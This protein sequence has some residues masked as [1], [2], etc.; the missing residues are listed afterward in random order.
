V[1]TERSVLRSRP[2]VALLGAEAISSLGSQMTFLA[3]PWFVLVTTGSA[4]KMSIVLAVEILPIALLGIP[5]GALIARFGARTTMVIGD[6]GR[7]PLMLA[8]PLLQK[9]G[10]LTFPLL[11]VFVFLMGC[12][13]A[14][15]FSAQRLILPELVGDDERTVGQANAIFEGTQRATALLGPSMAGVLIAVIGATNVLYLD[16]A[17]YFVSFLILITLVPRRPPIAES[18]DAHG[19]LAGI[20]F[21]FRDYLLRVLAI[22]ALFL[23]MFGQMMVASLPVLAFDEYDES[24]A[25]AGLFFAAFGAGS[26]VG[27]VLAVKLLPKFDP[28]RLGAVALVLLTVP[29][30]LLGLPLPAWAV[31]AVL[32]TGAI[33]GPLVNAPLIGVLTTRTPESLRPKVMTGVITMAM[34]AGPVGLLVVGPLLASWGPRPVLLFVALGQFL[35]SLPF[36]FVALRRREPTVPITLEAA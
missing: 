13:I 21:L 15:Y 28:I 1:T 32:F 20:R 16:A 6:A 17:S 24:S 23:N 7:A 12:F 4:A 34:L 5:S 11:L 2:L 8:I 3:L 30:P 18:E 27:A 25:I 9:A 26:L 10:V 29:I 33:F 36:A 35:A 14:P 19:L 31:M 22:T